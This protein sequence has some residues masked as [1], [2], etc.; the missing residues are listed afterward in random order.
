MRISSLIRLI[1]SYM[2]LGIMGTVIAIGIFLIG[3][4]LFY[5]KLMKG[6]KKININK[7]GLWS[8][9][10]IYMIIVLMATIGDR[11]EGYESINL[12]LFSSYKEAYNS[13]SIGQWRNIILNILMFVPIG[14]MMPLLIKKCET[15]YITYLVGILITLFIET[16]QLITKRG[17]F[18]IDDIINNSLGCAIGYGII[19]TFIYLFKRKST[20]QKAL[21]TMTY[22]I[23]LI[24]TIISFSLIFIN[25]NKQ[26]LGNLWIE[27]SYN[28]DMSKVEVSTNINLDNKSEKAYVYESYVGNKE[29]AINLANEIFSKVNTS[30]DI[31][32]NDEYDDTI[33]FKS[34]DGNYDLWVDYKGLTTWFNNYSQHEY[35]GKENLTYEEVKNLLVEFDIELPKEVDFKDNGN[36]NYSILIDMAKLK[37]YY[38]VGE[39]T[40]IINENNK[41]S[42]FNNN[43]IS[44]KPYKEYEIL[45]V[46]EAYDKILDGD[47]SLSD[48]IK[49]DSKIEVINIDLA[50]NSDTKGFY[51]P[52]Y[53]FKV[54]IDGENNHHIYIPALIK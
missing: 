6:S 7:L 8:I 51:Q 29:D 17:I 36:G 41:I 22:H 42:S 50:Y 12:Y 53:K 27:S 2:L 38:L 18:E 39:L 13:F 45:S 1:K 5:K 19:M 46:K 32:Q 24:V 35:K 34:T 52:V 43:I 11:S 28:I 44:Y 25:Y 9:F 37:D 33:V 31:S 14:F 10:L 20:N 49:K 3:Y 16:L 23:P 47:F 26:E 54:N 30:I 21:R 15:W 40:C 48:V 4:F